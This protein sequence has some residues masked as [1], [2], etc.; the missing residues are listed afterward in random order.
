MLDLHQAREDAEERAYIAEGDRETLRN[1]LGEVLHQC[2][3]ANPN[4]TRE[5]WFV[6]ARAAQIANGSPS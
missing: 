2:E 6:K 3:L 5:P 4:V 1:V